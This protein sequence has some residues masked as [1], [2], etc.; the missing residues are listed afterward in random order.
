[1][2]FRAHH[3]FAVGLGMGA[4]IFFAAATLLIA[5][6]TG[7]KVFN[8]TAT[9]WGGSIQFTASMLYAIAFLIQFVIGGLTGIMFATVPVDWQ[10]TDTYF[11]VAHF[12]Y[13]LIGGIVFALFAATF[14]WFP[15]MTGR[16]LDERLGKIQFWLWVIGFNGTFGVQHLL[17]LMGMPRRVYT[18]GDNPGWALLNGIST[19][20]AFLMAAGTLVLIWNVV[21]SLRRGPIAGNN[22]WEGFTLEWYTSSP[23]P[24][25]NFESLP[26]I[27]SRRPVWDADHPDLADWKTS[28]T[29]SD[30]GYRADKSTVA[31]TAFIVS[32]AIFFALLLVAYVVFNTA[33]AST[34]P[35]SE[36]T[37]DVVRTATFSLFLL[38][39]SLTCWLAEQSLRR[40]KRVWFL[41][42]LALTILLGLIFLAGQAI[43]YAG[44][45]Q[46]EITVSTNLFA[47]TF[48]TVTGFHGLHVIAGIIALSILWVMAKAG[49]ITAARSKVFGAVAIYWHFVDFVWIGVFAIIYLRFLQ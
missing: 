6:P 39:S 24:V 1:M 28:Q 10:L 12:H 15:K 22:P 34:G 13:V 32:E 9:L 14:Y 35:T 25:E 36:T 17:G 40:G 48:F 47:S 3:M 46:Q 49:Y 21:A 7:I 5:L 19:V 38:S 8:W 42:M 27:E 26:V 37:L 16:L 33:D 45:L 23:P 30:S 11:V 2:A 20:S 29:P 43:E 44:L 31:A 41:S 4:N 18:Y